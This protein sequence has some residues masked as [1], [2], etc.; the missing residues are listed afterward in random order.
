M[1]NP[2]IGTLDV[3]S[4]AVFSIVND[5]DLVILSVNQFSD[6]SKKEKDDIIIEGSEMG[7]VLMMP[8]HA[9]YNYR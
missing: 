4:C 7:N 5:N 3:G 1:W 8:F 9:N 2:N 6:V